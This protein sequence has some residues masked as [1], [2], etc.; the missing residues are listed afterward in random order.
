MTDI[1][2]STQTSEGG[3][4]DTAVASV[5]GRPTGVLGALMSLAPGS[6]D[7]AGVVPA[8]YSL[9]AS[10][11]V[12]SG[13][14][15]FGLIEDTV[16]EIGGDQALQQFRNGMDQVDQGFAVNVEWELLPGIGHELFLA[17]RTPDL[18]MLASGRPPRWADFEPIFGFAV[19]DQVILT[20]LV[21]RFA[22]SPVAMQ[23][24][25]RLV[26]VGHGEYEIYTLENMAFNFHLSLAFVGDYCVLSTDR[27]HVTGALDAVDG[28]RTLAG[29]I[30][31]GLSRAQVAKDLNAYVYLDTRPAQE[32]ALAL[33]RQ[34]LPSEAMIWLG[35][36][37]RV[38]P[39]LGGYSLALAAQDSALRAEGYGELPV[40]FTGLSLL[41]VS[42][43]V[44]TQQLMARQAGG[45]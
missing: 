8:D 29:D 22:N 45:R 18:D 21:K 34:N 38:M 6:T 23:Q 27:G 37:E 16:L 25:W 19:K 7:S 17:M 4:K 14:K 41:A 43:A 9:L 1:Q 20:D 13:E 35:T 2:I 33:L 31:Y 10:L 28:G 5:D 24:G 11:Q 42:G 39:S 36:I 32:A 12:E 15:L 44:Q 40:A 26:T 3:F 30:Q